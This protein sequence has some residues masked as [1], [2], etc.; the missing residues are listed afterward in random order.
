MVVC[1]AS[2]GSEIQDLLTGLV[3]N[4]REVHELVDLGLA[5]IEEGCRFPNR[6]NDVSSIEKGASNG[7]D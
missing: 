7:A 3:S 6:E 2:G 4:V 5:Q 1:A